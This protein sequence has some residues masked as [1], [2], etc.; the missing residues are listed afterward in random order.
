MWCLTCIPPGHR[1]TSQRFGEVQQ[2]LAELGVS[3]QR[4]GLNE[5]YHVELIKCCRAKLGESSLKGVGGLYLRDRKQ[6]RTH[7]TQ[8]RLCVTCDN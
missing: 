2:K 1:S 8:A 7:S 5:K 3:P 4:F 6:A